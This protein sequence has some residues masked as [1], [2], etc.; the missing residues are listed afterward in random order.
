MPG[1]LNSWMMRLI[2]GNDRVVDWACSGNCHWLGHQLGAVAQSC[3]LVV[4]TKWVTGTVIGV[5]SLSSRLRGEEVLA[6]SDA[7]L[8]IRR[9]LQCL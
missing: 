5:A 7:V 2:E 4:M 9:H 8:D 1:F 6:K 3:V